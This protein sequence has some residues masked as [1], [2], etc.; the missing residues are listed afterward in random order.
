MLKYTSVK[1]IDVNDWD[2]LVM[3]TYG[4]HYSFQQQE[5]CQPR[6]KVSLTVPSEWT[7]EEEMHESIAEEVNGDEM[8]VKFETWLA[9]DPNQPL[10]PP[11]DA[12]YCISMFWERN[13]YP[14]LHTVAND[15]YAK[16]LIE[17]GS[18]VIDI[19]W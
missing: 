4:K 7:N 2:S 15:L 8:G 5:G 12:D 10:P 18:Y 14:D 16:G 1:T 17:A 19:D 3:N 11:D 9:R 13:F 6:G